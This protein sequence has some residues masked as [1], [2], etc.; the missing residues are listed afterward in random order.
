MIPQF[1]NEEEI[2]H[3]LDLAEVSCSEGLSV[4][5]ER[6]ACWVPII[7]IISIISTISIFSIISIISIVDSFKG[8][9]KEPFSRDKGP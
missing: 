5:L 3:L 1:L 7:S 8:R 6:K 2:Q 9:T 4:A